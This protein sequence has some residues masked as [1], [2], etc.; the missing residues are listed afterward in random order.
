MGRQR[1]SCVRDVGVARRCA[2]SIAAQYDRDHPDFADFDFHDPSNLV[3]VQAA[4]RT[5]TSISSS[6]NEWSE[7]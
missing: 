7:F 6:A 2:G 4:G 3:G 5:T 1:R